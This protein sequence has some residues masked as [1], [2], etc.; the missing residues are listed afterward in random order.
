MA[1]RNLTLK[2]SK[3]EG[4]IDNAPNVL[5]VWYALAGYAYYVLGTAIVSQGF[6]DQMKAKVVA[7]WPKITTPVSGPFTL[8]DIKNEVGWNKLSASLKVTAQMHVDE[9]TGKI[10]PR[11]SVP[12]VTSPAPKPV[13]KH[14][15]W[16]RLRLE[17]R[18]ILPHDAPTKNKAQVDF[19]CAEL[20]FECYAGI[21][22]ATSDNKAELSSRL[23]RGLTLL[24]EQNINYRSY[25]M[26][27]VLIDSGKEDVWSFKNNKGA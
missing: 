19:I 16:A 15:D 24:Q 11:P 4:I 27:E 3:I 12:M 10:K 18:I 17:G 9:V 21:L 5:F 8:A 1:A 2:D 23:M 26:V 13:V 20:G 22:C 14:S 7:D 6:F 25:T